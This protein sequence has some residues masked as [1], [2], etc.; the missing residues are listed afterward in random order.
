MWE[1]LSEPEKSQRLRGQNRVSNNK[2]LGIWKTTWD[3]EEGSEVYQP[4]KGSLLLYS[5][6]WFPA[7]HFT[8]LAYKQNCR[9]THTHTNTQTQITVSHMHTHAHTQNQITVSHVHTHMRKTELLSHTCTRTHAS[10]HTANHILPHAHI[11]NMKE[12]Q[13]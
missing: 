6:S 5:F 2:L 3:C 4:L 7:I 9:C 11:H 12:K 1:G 13:N 10:M 8:T